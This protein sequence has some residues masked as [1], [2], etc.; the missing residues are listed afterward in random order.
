[1]LSASSS[2][3]ASLAT[4][5][6][7]EDLDKGAFAQLTAHE[8]QQVAGKTVP[9]IPW[10]VKGPP[11]LAVLVFNCACYWFASSLG[12]IKST[13]K[14]ELDIDNS[15]YGVLSTSQSLVNTVVPFLSGILI[16]YWGAEWC[17]IASSAII[18]LGAL[19]AGI[20]ATVS[21]Y[22]LLVAGE[23]I[24][25]FGSITI[26]TTQLKILSHWF[27]GTHLGL[28]LGANNAINRVIV[29]ISKATAIPIADASNWT[30]VIWVPAF[31]SFAVLLINI[32]YVL[33]E[34]RIPAQYRP[35]TGRQA[36]NLHEQGQGGLRREVRKAWAVVWGLPAVFWYITLTQLLQNGTVQTFVSLQA[37]MVTVTRGAGLLKAGWISAVAQ[38]PV[39]VFAPL[40]GAFFDRFG[41][42][43]HLVPASAGLFVLLFGLMGWTQA[44]AIGLTILQGIALAIN[45]LPFT[46][47][48]S[49][50]VPSLHQ[51][52]TAQ[53]TYQ[54]FINSG[55]VVVS[56]AAGAI[57][58]ET[59]KGR[60]SY[61]NVLYFF[62]A[63]KS[64]DILFGLSYIVLDR[65]HLNCL[66]TKSERNR[67]I[68]PPSVEFPGY[69]HG[70]GEGDE[71]II[72][73]KVGEEKVDLE[74]EG[75]KDNEAK[76]KGWMLRPSPRFT[77]AGLITGAALTVAAWAVYL[78]YSQG[79]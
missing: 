20:G 6:V 18:F 51:I 58:D 54:A 29:V 8:G 45:L 65:T 5:P 71:R 43:M 21:S 36:A 57:Q 79:S 77:T 66:L 64:L 50:L 4:T 42:R 37:D 38:V 14:K 55:H 76:E 73:R 3:T 56:T 67:P 63:L 30:W 32:L 69:G 74:R 61:S 15:Q 16:D 41:Y 31:I 7:K 34:M 47:A 46:C 68:A 17:S 39:I 48:I 25:G 49:L 33:Y 27:F 13:L 52:G 70:E 28:A 19:L 10:S 26:E 22:G 78:V 75:R 9:H 44:D 59:P 72:S 53:G 11:L 62:I 1:M 23:V 2:P 24:V 12:P 60:Y 35:L 40:T